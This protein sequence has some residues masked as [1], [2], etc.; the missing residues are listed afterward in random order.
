VTFLRATIAVVVVLYVVL[1]VLAFNGASGLYGPLAVPLVLAALVAM[2][3]A[4]QRF[5][6]LTPRK[7]HFRDREENPPK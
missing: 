6:G 3:V 5:I 1:W 7:Q 4:L 2:G